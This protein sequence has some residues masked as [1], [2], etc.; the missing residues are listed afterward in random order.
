[1]SDFKAVYYGAR[2]L[3]QHG[4]PY[5]VNEWLREYRADGGQLPSDPTMS[6]QF[7][8]AVPVFI[9][10]PTTLLLISPLA[11]LAW[12][13]AHIIWM[14]LLAGG[15]LLAAF[16]MWKLAG[17][18]APGVSLFLICLVL[19]NCELIFSSGRSAVIAICLCVVA[20][21]CFLQE[22][23][24]PAGILCMAV[25]LV[26]KPHDAGLVWLFF[27]LLGGVYRKRA[28]QT[29][30]F[31][32]ILSI[33]AVLW[34]SQVSPHWIEEWHSN[35]AASSAR[36]GLGDPGP[37][38]L[39]MSKP[40]KIIDLQTVISLFRDEPSF[41]NPTSYLI[42]G[43]LLL[44]GAFHTLRFG[45]S[46]K[47]AWIALAAIAALSMLPIYHRQYDAKMLLLTVPACAMLWS[48][49]GFIGRFAF[50]FNAAGIILTGDI[51]LEILTNI[52]NNLHLNSTGY[53]GKIL[54]V[55][56][57]RPAPVILLMLGTFYLWVYLRR[58][59]PESASVT[60]VAK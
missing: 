28:L 32:V 41:Y 10:L 53:Y 26:I 43:A 56:L 13:P 58:A 15:L 20:A 16:L 30:L 57:M 1:M 14:F 36:G 47:N 38:S 17:N 21:W 19:I 7:H 2:C 3:I 24:V 60:K 5:N 42:G 45:C 34:V 37:T 33:P 9:N 31:T 4:D 54:T 23:F 52:Y 40:D 48:E 8:R 25:S 22:R 44:L 29:L 49:G 39:N 51:P 27:V 12:G 59:L 50:A 6:W 46:Q 11:M 35:L 55:L 18:Y